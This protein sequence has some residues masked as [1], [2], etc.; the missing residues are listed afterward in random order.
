M[1]KC[2][3]ILKHIRKHK[4]NSSENTRTYKNTRK[5]KE[6]LEHIRKQQK[7]KYQ[8]ILES[9]RITLKIQETSGTI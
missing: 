9:A 2:K 6:I 4:K 3:E 1:R 5:Y 7:Q 8:N